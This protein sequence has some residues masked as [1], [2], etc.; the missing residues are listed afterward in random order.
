LI[1]VVAGG[2]AI[3]SSQVVL[4]GVVLQLIEK[5]LGLLWAE[6]ML[7]EQSGPA[8]T[9]RVKQ[10]EQWAL[11]L[12]SKDGGADADVWPV[13][14]EEV[15]VL[16]N[17]DIRQ[18]AAEGVVACGGGRRWAKEKGILQQGTSGDDMQQRGEG[19]ILVKALLQ[20]IAQ[21]KG[22]L[23]PLFR[24]AGDECRNQRKNH[25]QAKHGDECEALC[26]RRCGQGG[27]RCAGLRNG[28]LAL[29][30]GWAHQKSR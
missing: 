27:A 11:V 13:V 18:G 19:C 8:F 25:Q 26:G 4:I 9:I 23:E 30:H 6:A 5:T 17:V 29:G 24:I 12:Q 14:H 3:E 1:D 16:R 10:A 2:G 7:P 28:W 15:R 22:L 21:L 20:L